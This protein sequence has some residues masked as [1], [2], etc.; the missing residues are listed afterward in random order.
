VEWAIKKN[1]IASREE[2]Y[3]C[4][5]NDQ[6]RKEHAEKRERIEK[7]HRDEFEQALLDWEKNRRAFIRKEFNDYVGEVGATLAHHKGPKFYIVFEIKPKID[8]VGKVLRQLQEYRTRTKPSDQ[9]VYSDVEGDLNIP[10]YLHQV[11]LITSDRR[12]DGVFSGQGFQVF[13]PEEVESAKGGVVH[14]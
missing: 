4:G 11:V 9:R 6:Q 2:W 1:L 3:H 5:L 10:E 8:S 7:A 12:Y 13:H 14:E